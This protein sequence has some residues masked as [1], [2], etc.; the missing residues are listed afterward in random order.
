[1][2]DQF[3]RIQVGPAHLRAHA[4][5]YKGTSVS[6]E[7]NTYNQES[8]DGHIMETYLRYV[9][10]IVRAQKFRTVPEAVQW[11]YNGT[12]NYIFEYLKKREAVVLNNLKQCCPT[13]LCTRVQFT[14]AYGG[15][16]ATT[17]L[18]LLHH[19]YR[20]LIRTTP[21]PTTNNNVKI[22]NSTQTFKNVFCLKI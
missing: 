8:S 15:A 10:R 5:T 2:L 22:F 7:Y 21:T 11:R 17:L 9:N 13:F 14:D 3:L 4:S 20:Y 19:H 1:V 6:E 18:L 12:W 16:G